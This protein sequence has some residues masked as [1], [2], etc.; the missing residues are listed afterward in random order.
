M[1]GSRPAERLS[2]YIS[3][4]ASGLG[5]YLLQGFFTSLLGGVPGLPGI[6]LRGLL[7]RFVLRM[8][9]FA[10][11]EPNVRFRHARGIRLGRGVYID[12][13]VYL[14]A[15]PQGIDLGDDVCVM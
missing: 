7:Y 10:A 12:Q 11:I 6:G 5:A 4:Q 9:G 15:C 8:D 2:Y 3:G 14:H 13:G 1:Q